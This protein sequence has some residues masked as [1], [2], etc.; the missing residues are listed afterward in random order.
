MPIK[1]SNPTNPVP[2]WKDWTAASIKEYIHNALPL[3][4]ADTVEEIL[5]LYPYI[6]YWKLGSW[7]GVS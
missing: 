6:D 3:L 4:E 1:P 2:I 7:F 5:C